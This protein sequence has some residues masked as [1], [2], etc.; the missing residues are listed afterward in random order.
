MR[1][2]GFYSS[3]TVRHEKS[4]REAELPPV[5]LWRWAAQRGRP[6]LP[7]YFV[8]KSTSAASSSSSDIGS[9]ATVTDR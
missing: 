2:P 9:V 3:T 1:D 8:S 5:G 7:V 6:S 4:L